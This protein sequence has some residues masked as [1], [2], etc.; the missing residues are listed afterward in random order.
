MFSIRLRLRLAELHRRDGGSLGLV[1][2]GYLCADE[3][4]GSMVGLRPGRPIHGTVWGSGG[5]ACRVCRP[6]AR[7]F[8]AST[9][10]RVLEDRIPSS[11]RCISS[12][13][14]CRSAVR[15]TPTA[16]LVGNSWRGSLR[17]NRLP[18]ARRSSRVIGLQMYTLQ[19]LYFQSLTSR[20]L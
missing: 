19:L 12:L 7:S 18:R 13:Q 10:P 4:G 14:G 2:Q 11:P 9:G 1:M 5:V 16:N 20:Y 3:K 6:R 17:C 8:I 15:F